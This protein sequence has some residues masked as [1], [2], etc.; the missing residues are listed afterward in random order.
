MLGKSWSLKPA[1][2][3]VNGDPVVPDGSGLGCSQWLKCNET[4]DDDGTLKNP[5]GSLWTSLPEAMIEE[6]QELQSRWR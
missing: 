5:D 1:Y 6:R 4:G 3:F 2:K